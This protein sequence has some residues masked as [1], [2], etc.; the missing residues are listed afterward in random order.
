MDKSL[1]SREDLVYFAKVAENARRF[2]DMVDTM[3]LV[4]KSG[5][6]L[7]LEE[8]NLFSVAYKSLVGTKRASWRV[9]AAV[10]NREI[11]SRREE[12][13]EIIRKYRK[14]IEKEYFDLCLE[15]FDLLDNYLI[16]NPENEEAK[17]TYF[18]L[19]GDYQRYLGE[20]SAGNE[21]QEAA[22][23]A[24]RAY[25]IAT[26]L[27]AQ[28]L[29]AYDPIRLGLALNFSVF[30]Y[31]ILNNTQKACELA[32]KAFDEA[33]A[34]LPNSGNEESFNDSTLIMGILRENLRLW[35]SNSKTEVKDE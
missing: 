16:P 11:N 15:I 1:W 4:V 23:N 30:F 10:E 5:E 24:L 3:K 9:A 31:E 33:I 20:I 26:D 8:R 21:R 22:N 14:I 32:Q 27:A 7:N 12:R 6:P 34:K 18:K 13:S 19:K 25:Q 2:D 17:I 35:T 29:P 28:K